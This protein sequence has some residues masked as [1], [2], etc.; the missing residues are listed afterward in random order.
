MMSN[1]NKRRGFTLIELLVVIA[2][3]AILAA[4]LLPALAR[5]KEKGRRTSCLSNLKQWGL[6][7]GMYVDDNSQTFPQTKIPDGTLG[8]P[9]GYNEDNPSWTDVAEFYDYAPREGLD[10][11][12]N[13]L[14]P[15][16][17]SKPL[18]Y[19]KALLN[20]NSGIDNFNLGKTIFRCPTAIIDPLI[21]VNIRIAF[22]YGMNSKA[23]DQMPSS[24][25]YLRSPMI[26][27]PAKFVLFSEGRTLIAESP[28][29]GSVSKE[30]D[31]CK[32][33]V[34]TTAFSSRHTAGSSLTF[35]DG[36][37]SWYRYNYVCL[38]TPSKAA[39]PGRPDINWAAD[40]H[41]VP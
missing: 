26:A 36:H 34:Y 6:A 37:A 31:I 5:A 24:V 15:Y 3:I 7:M 38:N 25:L 16:V 35:A 30:T 13:G 18:Y 4:M 8:A 23:L 21:N 9:P 28:F 41:Q 11:W 1:L 29:Y 39:D 12:F 27:S 33:Q 19:Y 17:A 22:Q 2:I 20:D 10:A 32:P 40:G 14:P